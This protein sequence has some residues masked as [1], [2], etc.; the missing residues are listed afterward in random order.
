MGVIALDKAVRA[1]VVDFAM[2][3]KGRRSHSLA[4]AGHGSSG[5]SGNIGKI[6]KSGIVGRFSPSVRLRGGRQRSSYP[7]TG[8]GAPG[9]LAAQGPPRGV[10]A[11]HLP[12]RAMEVLG[13][14][15]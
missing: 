9:Q 2:A 11:I 7:W 12:G 4:R 15:K 5:A 6:E 1:A 3:A 10:V 8:Q 14:Q 13:S